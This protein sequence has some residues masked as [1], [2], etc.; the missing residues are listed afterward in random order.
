MN[1]MNIIEP[2]GKLGIL[3]SVSTLWPPP[4]FSSRN[5]PVQNRGERG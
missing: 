4:D 3:L 1:I 2:P 5:Y